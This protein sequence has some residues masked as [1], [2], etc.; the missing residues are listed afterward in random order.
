MNFQAGDVKRRRCALVTLQSSTST[1]YWEGRDIHELWIPCR[2]G[3][4]QFRHDIPSTPLLTSPMHT[5]LFGPILNPNLRRLTITR[6]AQNHESNSYCMSNIHLSRS[7]LYPLL[8]PYW[9]FCRRR[10]VLINALLA[11]EASTSCFLH[12]R[13]P[14]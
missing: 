14:I 10:V 12:S 6:P 11:T 7:R 5:V 2:P 9:S 3:S 13:K 8:H 1:T 4:R